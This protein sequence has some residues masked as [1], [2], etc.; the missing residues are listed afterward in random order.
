MIVTRG[1]FTVF[2]SR[3]TFIFLF[4]KLPHGAS[5]FFDTVIPRPP[6]G[7]EAGSSCSLRS[8]LA[9]G[10]GSYSA[11]HR[12]HPWSQKPW[13]KT[14]SCFGLILAACCLRKQNPWPSLN[15]IHPVDDTAVCCLTMSTP[16]AD[17][18]Q[19]MYLF[20]TESLLC[21]FGNFLS[22]FWGPATFVCYLEACIS[23]ICS[24]FSS[25]LNA[26]WNDLFCE[27]FCFL[28]GLLVPQFLQIQPVRFVY[29]NCSSTC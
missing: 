12:G 14:N 29:R 23:F 18:A 13:K 25:L 10:F 5:V 21:F 3:S 28:N 6:L 9:C 4:L 19:M 22:G 26:S 7:A 2:I 20:V 27:W 1:T 16:T 24:A 15:F 11:S 17:K 8:L